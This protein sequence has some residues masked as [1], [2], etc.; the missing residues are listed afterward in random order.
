MSQQDSTEELDQESIQDEDCS[1]VDEGSDQKEDQDEVRYHHFSLNFDPAEVCDKFKQVRVVLVA[2]SA[3]RAED[4]ANFL[5]ETFNG[6][7]LEYYPLEHLTTDRSRFSLFHIGPVLISDHGM[8]AAS[9]SIAL[10]ELFL[11]CQQADIL[12]K[13]TLIRFGTCKC[14]IFSIKLILSFL[15][16]AND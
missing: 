9:M 8:G 7:D 10:H 5:A 13:I 2:G 4:Q 16:A 6:T 3:H 12:D 14:F 1:V 15:S 11:M